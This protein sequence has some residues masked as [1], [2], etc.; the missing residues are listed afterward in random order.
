VEFRILG[1]VELWADG[2]SYPL[3]SRKERGVLAVLLCE[4]GRPVSAEALISRI[5]GAQASDGASGSLHQNVSRLRRRLRDAGGTDRELPKSSGSYV[6]QVSPA[7]V[8]ALRFR[9]RRDEARAAASRGD[10]KRAVTL[11]EEADALWRGT[12]LDGLDGDW[13]ESIRARLNEE[14][15]AAAVQRIGAGLRLGRHADLVGEVADLARQHPLD[16]KLLELHL[17][18]LYC[19]GRQSEALTAYFQADRRWREEAGLELG[20]ALRELHQL[21]L[22]EDPTLLA[23]APARAV[24]YQ[25]AVAQDAAAPSTLPRDNPDFTG[26][27]AELGTLSSWLGSV[28][29]ESTVPV[30]VI[31]GMTGVG[32]TTFAV[33][34]ARLLRERYPDQLHLS[35][36]GHDPDGE[37]LE[38]AKALGTLLR[39]LGLPDK[40][41]PVGTEDRA[42]R[43]RAMLTGRRAL[44]ML[45]DA[46]D[47]DQVLPLL[48]SAPGSLVLITTRHRTLGLP[49]ILPLS[50]SP[51]PPADAAA[52]FARAS[53][54]GTGEA[55]DRAAVARVV[56]LCGYLPIE[57]EIAGRRLRSHSAWS[58]S[59][60]AA[61]LREL[62]SADRRVTAALELSYRYLTTDQ[63]R[64]FLRLA[65]HPGDSFTTY[66]ATA[67]D[68]EV[69]TAE[70]GRTLD[71][72]H[73]YHLIEEP[74]TGRFRFHD[75]I[76]EYAAN[77]MDSVD[78]EQDQRLALGR[79]LD[80]YLRLVDQADRIIRP[81]G[82][83]IALPDLV[84][85][86]ALPPLTTRRACM[87]L[88]DAEKTSLLVM[89]RH[90]AAHGWHYHAGQLAHLLAGFLDLWGDWADAIDLHR[91]AID[92]W[93][94]AGNASGETTALIDLGFI[95]SRTGL[96]AEAA[97]LLRQALAIAR[98]MSDPAGEASA[99]DT[100]GIIHAW[101]GSYE[102]ALASHDQ[103][104]ALWHG[105]GD[106]R[107]EADALGRSVLPAAR[108]GRRQ[109][110]L[111][112]A[113]FALAAY[114]ELGD[115]QGETNTLNNIGGLQQDA[116]C[117][118]EALDRYKQARARF[119]EI[120]DRQ[121]EAI[122]LNNIADVRRLSG[123]HAE[124]LKDYRTALSI[125]FDIGDERS[126]AVTL[127]GMAAAFADSGDHQAALTCYAK[128]LVRASELAE[129]RTQAASHLGLGAV[130]LM[131]GHCHPAAEDYRTAL[132]LSK[133]IGDPVQEG[134]AW[135]GLGSALDDT[136]NAAG[137]RDCW[138]SALAIFETVGSP[139]AE[140]VRA[141]LEKSAA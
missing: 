126:G 19:S 79:L 118:D 89:A 130:H 87:E 135:D 37:P 63:Q 32:K 94:A 101:S 55:A 85:P 75:L 82:R 6:L 67:L 39:M 1:P 72:L 137:A 93:R 22:H 110:A 98:E 48:P 36:R 49:G 52:L 114:R 106:G 15:L 29:V 4:L 81:F 50:L 80:Y 97:D 33:H 61:R 23:A 83:R 88:L 73:D 95:L 18:A 107:G 68:G 70:T 64:L 117:Y 51:L 45:D 92:A 113:E 134:H 26:R 30:A 38:P 16:E 53:G 27:A 120:G 129:R 41:I 31:S 14:R 103:A 35:L 47:S 133:E 127:N 99:L 46:L 56:R 54:A 90:A 109:D 116:R 76:R 28:Q 141:R 59:D 77:R 123:H 128:A 122:A 12:P 8:D 43:W 91:R 102:E 57:L 66:A 13:V 121:G 84:D 131:M 21:M 136:G 58:V 3:G 69:S 20:Q 5:W 125:F 2:R 115:L 104:L 7:D 140:V 111:R 25:R 124:A 105:L 65:L 34:A 60:L 11:Y 138:R 78:G 108:L 132:Q 86:P 44:V 119:L 100:M 42:A 71:A 24:P 17:R 139:L 74:L 112:R 96:H 62:R 10:D 9:T 40:E